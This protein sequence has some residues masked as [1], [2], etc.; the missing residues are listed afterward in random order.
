MFGRSRQGTD[1][2]TALAFQCNE[3]SG[4]RT[5]ESAWNAYRKRVQRYPV[6]GRGNFYHSMPGWTTAYVAPCAGWPLPVQKTKLRPS[7]G[8]LMLA[9]HLYEV[10]SPY[11][12]TPAMREAIGGTV[13]TVDDDAHTSTY[14]MCPDKLTD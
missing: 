14:R 6:T 11:E 13:V 5:F 7:G 10:L 9:G 2:T 3:D 4:S 1:F 8:S 12:F